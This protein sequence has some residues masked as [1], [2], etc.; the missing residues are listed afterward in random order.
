MSSLEDEVLWLPQQ[1]VEGVA[2]YA[3]LDGNFQQ[4]EG[5]WLRSGVDRCDR[6]AMEGFEVQYKVR[7]KGPIAFQFVYRL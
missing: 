7:Y 5:A 2:V 4:R 1:Q 3:A 6:I